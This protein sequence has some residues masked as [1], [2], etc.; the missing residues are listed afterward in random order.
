[1]KK[2]KTGDLVIVRT[3]DDKG[4][5]GKVL[6]I[7]GDRITVQG[8]NILK[9]FVKKNVLSKGAE[10]QVFEI[11]RSISVSNVALINPETG[12]AEKVGIKIED[13]KKKRIYKKTNTEV[14]PFKEEPKEK[15]QKTKTKSKVK[16]GKKKE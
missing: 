10:G 8:V 9:K 2:I 12:K 3:G 15:E 13:K 6:N 4:V 5:K 16:V 14:K 7:K 1:M 11:E